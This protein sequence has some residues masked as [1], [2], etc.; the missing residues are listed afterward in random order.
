MQP[1]GSH[2]KGRQWDGA[3]PCLKL[4]QQEVFFCWESNSTCI[5]LDAKVDGIAGFFFF[6]QKSIA[7]EVEFAHFHG[8]PL[9]RRSERINCEVRWSCRSN[10][11]PRHSWPSPPI[12]GSIAIFFLSVSR[13]F[14][15]PFPYFLQESVVCLKV[16]FSTK[17]QIKVSFLTKI[18]IKL[19]R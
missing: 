2:V 4:P 11:L 10:Y 8:A 12:F 16:S 17:I 18:Q 14:W 7:R 1:R 5:N 3:R 19:I 9:K 13:H 6:K 15:C